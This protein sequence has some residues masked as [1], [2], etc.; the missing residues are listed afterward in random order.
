L[1]AQG[2]IGN[3]IARLLSQLPGRV[4]IDDSQTY[5]EENLGTCM[6]IG[7][8][9][10][11]ASKARTLARYLRFSLSYRDVE[12]LLIERGLPADHTTIWRWVQ[13]YAPELSK[14]CERELKPTNGSWPA[15]ETYI[16][17]GESWR[18][19]YR[20]VD[21]TGATIDFWFSTERDAAPA[22]QFFQKALQVP[23]HPRPRHNSRRQPVLP[24]GDS[25]AK[26]R[27]EIR[28][29]MPLVEPA[30]FKFCCGT[31]PS[32]DQAASECESRFSIV[33]W[34]R[35]DGSRL[36]GSAH[37]PERPSEVVAE[38]GCYWADSVHPPDPRIEN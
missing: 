29:P 8:T 36:R 38:N 5:E 34:I 1:S 2:A 13:R 22:K 30:V 28:K 21:S 11:G 32:R 20:A 31:G 17:Q 14:R 37:D 4:D 3:G 24:E 18:Y 27:A 15:D 33:R 12:E 9:D 7:G 19:L 6:L 25:R 26:A 16:C 23:G 35:A 10:L